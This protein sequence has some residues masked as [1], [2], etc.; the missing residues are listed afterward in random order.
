MINDQILQIM[1]ISPKATIPQYATEGSAGMDLCACFDG[2]KD[3]SLRI[4]P[5]STRVVPTGIAIVVPEGYEAQVRSRSGLAA[6]HGVHVL[7]SPGTIDSDYRGEILVILHN[8]G[9]SYLNIVEGDRIAQLVVCPVTRV[10]W[11][12]VDMLPITVRG[13]GGLGSTGV[14]GGYAGNRH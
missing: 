2:E 9:E 12:E 6:K 1:R 4:A 11:Q 5:G 7:N 10:N 13:V 14:G 8:S 3:D